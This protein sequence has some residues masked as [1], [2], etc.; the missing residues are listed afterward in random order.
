MRSLHDHEGFRL[1]NKWN[2]SRAE[3]HLT[4][5]GQGNKLSLSGKG[6]VT[7]FDQG[8]MAFSG[9]GF[10]FLIDL[11]HAAFESVQTEEAVSKAGLNPDQFLE[12]AAICLGT[13]DKVLLFGPPLRPELHDNCK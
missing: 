6:I 12:S 3:I 13:G 10:E 7:A 8:G 2:T 9:D 1:L 5:N 4:F 11:S